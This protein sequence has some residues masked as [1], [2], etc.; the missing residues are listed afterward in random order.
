MLLYGSMNDNI[1][2]IGQFKS[3]FRIHVLYFSKGRNTIHFSLGGEGGGGKLV[4][5]PNAN[6]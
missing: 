3:Q 4:K 5:F 2:G 6:N 1:S